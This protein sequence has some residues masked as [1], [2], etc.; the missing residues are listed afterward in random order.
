MSKSTGRSPE[1][2]V[3]P[4]SRP[5]GRSPK[6]GDQVVRRSRPT[7]AHSP[8][9]IRLSQAQGRS[10]SSDPRA[11]D[12]DVVLQKPLTINPGQEI[13]LHSA[14]LNTGG[15]G[16]QS[17]EVPDTDIE[18]QFVVYQQDWT[19]ENRE[20]DGQT[21]GEH[22]DGLNYIKSQVQ[23]STTQLIKVNYIDLVYDGKSKSWGNFNFTIDFVDALNNPVRKVYPIPSYTPSTTSHRVTLNLIITNLTLHI[24]SNPAAFGCH[25]QPS[26]TSPVDDEVYTPLIQTKKFKI[27]G[28]V[29]GAAELAKIITDTCVSNA[30]DQYF[31]IPVNSPFLRASDV[32]TGVSATFMRTDGNQWYTIEQKS[33]IPGQWAGASQVALLF[34]EGAS[35]FYWEYLHTPL[36]DTSGNQVIQTVKYGDNDE[37]SWCTRA[38]GVAFNSLEP[39][40]FWQDTLGFDLDT[41]LIKFQHK[42]TVTVLGGVPIVINTVTTDFKDGVNV[43]GG[44]KDLDSGVDKTDQVVKFF[45]VPMLE[46]ENLVS[47]STLTTTIYG[48]P[49]NISLIDGPYYQIEVS[50]MGDRELYDATL[51]KGNVL[52][53]AGRYYTSSGYLDVSGGTIPYVHQGE[54]MLVS[55]IRVR[56]LTPEGQLARLDPDNHVFVLFG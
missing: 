26:N 15:T 12:F 46:S 42:E 49:V 13:V 19:K 33:T 41:L 47:T 23:T 44:L 51:R 55:S 28:G 3:D 10:L 52:A 1:D 53:V 4:R 56:V 35:A 29:Y 5:S 43:T 34:D 54:P 31:T 39:Q 14:F 32:Q 8:A 7:A 38:G 20:Y 25:A 36:Y 30:T 18:M 24:V 11:C 40:A 9:V 48:N 17:I 21:T 22:P 50:A 37:W 6:D 45:Q 2:G 16:G 27:P